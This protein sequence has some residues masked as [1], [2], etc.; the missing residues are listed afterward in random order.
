MGPLTEYLV[1]TGFKVRKKGHVK[2]LAGWDEKEG[3]EEGGEKE[4]YE[5]RVK[6]KHILLSSNYAQKF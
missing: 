3:G 4:V 2:K 1:K 6:K 5:N